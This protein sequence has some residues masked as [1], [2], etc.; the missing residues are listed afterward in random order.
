MLSHLS[1]LDLR[2]NWEN[3]KFSLT[4][5]ISFLGIEL[6]LVEQTARLTQEHAQ[7]V[8]NCLN[9]FKSRTAV[10]LKQFQRLLGHMAAAATVTPLGLLHMRP[11][12]HWLHGRVPR[13]AWQRGPSHTG[14]PSNLHPVVRPCISSGRSAPGTGLQA[15]SGL[16]GCWHH[17]LGG[18]ERSTGLQCRGFGGPPTAL[19]HHLPS[20]AGS[21]SGLEPSQG[22]LTRQA[23][24]G[25]HRQHCDHCI[26]QPTRWSTLP[27]HVATRL[28]PPPLESEAFEVTSC[29]SHS[30]LAQAGSRQTVTRCAPREWRLHPQTVQLIWRRFGAAQVDLFASLETSHCQLFYC[31]TEGTLRMDALHTAGCR[32]FASMRFPQ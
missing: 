5:R 13:C 27:L 28:P 29:H 15:C 12:Q 16:H 20:V 1:Q 9:M 6:D 25:Q 7:S 18:G 4:E 31:L 26:H 11:L 2:V 14:L 22:A 32:A 23:R 30:G 3:S 8:L 17:R 21:T 24:T 10:P 19:A